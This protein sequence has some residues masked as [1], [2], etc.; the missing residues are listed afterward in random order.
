MDRVQPAKKEEKTSAE[1]ITRLASTT[2]T[3]STSISDKNEL[4]NSI[5]YLTVCRDKILQRY[6]FCLDYIVYD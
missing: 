3:T 4:G 1:S 2:S 6:V 5:P